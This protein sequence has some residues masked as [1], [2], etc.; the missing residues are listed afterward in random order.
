MALAVALNC[1]L[2]GMIHAQEARQRQPAREGVRNLAL[3]TYARRSFNY[4][5]RMV[6]KDGLPYFNIFWTEPAEAA[7]DWPDFGD[8]MS[9]QYQAVVMAR[10]MTG[11]TLPIEAVWQQKDSEF[12]RPSDWTAH[13]ASDELLQEGCG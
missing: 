1:G 11:E 12:D 6:D 7:H 10:N 5:N 13:T 3:E 9:R 8:V 2:T 4:C